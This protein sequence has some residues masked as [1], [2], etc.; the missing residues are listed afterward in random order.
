MNIFL[1][2]SS[3]IQPSSEV[4]ILRASGVSLLRA[5]PA[6]LRIFGERLRLQREDEGERQH[7]GLR[8]HPHAVAVLLSVSRDKVGEVVRGGRIFG[9]EMR[10]SARNI[11]F[12]SIPQVSTHFETVLFNAR[13]LI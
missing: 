7:A 4:G 6:G 1:L 12:G 11:H 13:S 10:L 2:K 3:V 5:K 9:Q 8:D